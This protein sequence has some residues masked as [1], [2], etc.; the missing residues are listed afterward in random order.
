MT[1]RHAT[2]H[3]SASPHMHRRD[4]HATNSTHLARASA[5]KH[6][7][8]RRSTD[9]VEDDLQLVLLDLPTHCRR[10]ICARTE[11]QHGR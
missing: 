3:R 2:V 8:P 11:K 6:L 9:D 7:L 5:R 1:P 10:R 4:H